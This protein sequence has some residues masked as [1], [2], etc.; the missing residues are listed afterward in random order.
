MKEPL[1]ARGPIVERVVVSTSLDPLMSLKALATYSSIAPRTLR[2]YLELA[3]ED[4]LPCFRL[5]GKILVRRSEFDAWI[6]QYRTR[7]RPNLAR[8]IQVLG[9]AAKSPNRA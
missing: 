5:P 8:A 6:E 1:Q 4:A 7:G 3:P 2:Q 9:L